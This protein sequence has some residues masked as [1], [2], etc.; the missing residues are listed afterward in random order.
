MSCVVV[1]GVQTCAVPIFGGGESFVS[2]LS[3]TDQARTQQ[4]AFHAGV[5]TPE[6]MLTV[7]VDDGLAEGFVSRFVE[8]ETLGKRIVGDARYASA[9]RV[10]P[11]QCAEALAAI[12]ALDADALHFLPLQTAHVQI[13]ELA[14]RHHGYGEDLPVFEAAFA[15]LRAHQPAPTLPRVV[16]GDFRT[17][18]LLVDEQGLRGVLDW[19]LS[20]RGDAMEDL[21]W[22]C[23]RSWRFGCDALPVGGFGERAAFYEHYQTASGIPVDIAAVHFWEVLGT[24]KW[25][26]ICQW[27]SHRRL[28]G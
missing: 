4:A 5:R 16:H 22:L 1:T 25:G 20:H 2:V 6:V 12:H 13:G 15:W 28:P 24:L 23:L 21:G 14:Q 8:G 7:G 10:L 27:F 11:Q 19:E 9:R 3:K 17:G 18:N 26:V